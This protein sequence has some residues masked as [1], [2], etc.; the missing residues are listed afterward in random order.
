MIEIISQIGK[1][2]LFLG[3]AF[4]LPKKNSMFKKLLLREFYNLGYSSVGLVGF[5]SLFIGAVVS[6]HFYDSVATRN[7]PTPISLVGTSTLSLMVLELS[8]TLISL[9][10]TGKIGAYIASSI[11]TMKVTEQIDALDVMGINSVSF[12]VLPKI[13]ASLIF[14]PL[15]IALSVLCGSLGGYLMGEISGNWTQEDYVVGM[16]AAFEPFKFLYCYLKTVAFAFMMVTVPSFFGYHT[17]GSSIDVGKSSNLSV[18][19]TSISII[20]LNL[21]ITQLMFGK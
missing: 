20:V 12:L 2:L 18:V 8:P 4:A 1:Y 15:L 16:R 13:I 19:W 17:K 10:L 3:R 9:I 5:I 11:G 21:L 14:N 6:I 7:I